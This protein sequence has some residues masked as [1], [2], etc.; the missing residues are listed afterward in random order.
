MLP[1]APAATSPSS[2]AATTSAAVTSM[3]STVPLP[4]DPVS[5]APP[6]TVSFAPPSIY[7]GSIVAVPTEVNAGFPAPPP[8]IPAMPSGYLPGFQLPFAGTPGV[9][10]IAS[11]ITIRLTSENYMIWRAQVAPLLRS[12]LL[13]GYVDGSIFCPA[14]H[15]VVDNGG[16]M[17]PQPNPLHQRWVQQ[18]QA[19]LSPFVSSMTESVVGMVMFATTARDAWE[20]LAGAFAATSIACSSS[21]R[22]QMAELK[23]RDST[24]NVYFHKMKALADELTSIGQPLRDSEIVS[25]ILA[26]L[27]KEYD[28][29]YE[30]VNARREPMPLRDLY[31]QL[32]AT[33][34]R[35]ST[36]RE[37]PGQYYPAAHFAPMQ[38]SYSPMVNAT[39][40]GAPRGYRPPQYRPDSRPQQQQQPAHGQPRPPSTSTQGKSGRAPVVCQLCGVPPNAVAYGAHGGQQMTMDP[41]WYADSGATHHI[42]HD[43]DKLTT[44]EPY[45]GNEQVHTANGAG[46]GRGAR[47]EV[48]TPDDDHMETVAED[49]DPPVQQPSLH[50][51]QLH[52]APSG[53]LPMHEGVA[54]ASGFAPGSAAVQER[55]DDPASPLASSP[56]SRHDTFSPGT[57]G[58]ASPT[59]ADSPVAPPSSAP[60]TTVAPVLATSPPTAPSPPVTRRSRGIIQPK[61]RTDGTVAWTSI[62]AARDAARDTTEPSDYR[63]ALRIPHWRSAMETEF[64]ALQENGTW[65]LV[66]PVP[67]VNLIDSKWVFKVKLHADG[68][69]ERY[70]ARLVAKG[71]KQRYG[72]DYEETFSHVVKPATIRLLLSM[73][74]SRR[75]HLRQLDIQNAFLNGFLDEQVYMRQPPGFADPDKPGHYC[76]LI[77]S[78]YGLKQAPRAW[79]ARLSSVLGSLGFSPSATDTSL[80]ILRRSDITL[81]LLIYVD[82]IIVISS[83]A[84]AIPRLIA[85]LRSEFSVKDLGV[86]HYFLGIEVHSP[87]PDSLHLRQRKYALELLARAG[88]LK[89]SP[90]TTPMPSSERLCS[91]D[92]DLLS[93]D[94]ATQYR[95]LVGGLQ[96]L[97]VTRPDL[98]FVVNKVCQYLHEPR[99]P[100]ITVVKRILRYV[101]FTIDSGLLFRS[102]SSTLLSAFSDAD[103]AGSVDDRRSTG[104]YAIFYGGNLIA[105]SALFVTGAWYISSA[106]SSVMV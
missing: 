99:T 60:T 100:H 49:V 105:W 44:K 89:C 68:S 50:G 73:A 22:Q 84:A 83:T 59:P 78:L 98:S 88:M 53:L 18:D 90:V 38:P 34:H 1:A 8:G 40:Y 41:A 61:V 74:L 57:D 11:A 26:G 75:W 43:L 9:I 39:T 36:Q 25:Y 85:Q 80:F 92:G 28:A 67:G 20:T 87:S 16:V 14:A 66:P 56:A 6:G 65:N 35:K 64:S 15:T 2:A 81:F 106:T 3:V 21:I 24:M 10:S 47:L 94:E 62:L 101:R 19:I 23:R 17:I 29:L 33:E 102:S 51:S 91:T 32:C 104:G 96:Y 82:D 95:S 71:F 7:T 97:T 54:P 27:G 4:V 77:K 58:P 42:T 48:L 45:H 63:T 31:A 52:G 70:K 93:S 13:M 76:H 103:W 55:V 30:V 37:E 72:L 12:H 5:T 79:H 86:L 46:I 69:V